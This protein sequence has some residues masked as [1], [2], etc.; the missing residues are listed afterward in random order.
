MINAV[1]KNTLTTTPYESSAFPTSSG[2]GEQI[3]ESYIRMKNVEKKKTEQET[4][5]DT[6]YPFFDIGSAMIKFSNS[7][8]NTYAT[9]YYLMDNVDCHIL[10]AISRYKKLNGVESDFSPAKSLLW[11]LKS[12]RSIVVS[13]ITFYEDGAK[14][15]LR[16]AQTDF[17]IDFDF[18][19]PDSVFITT[20]KNGTMFVKDCQIDDLQKTLE[21]F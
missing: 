12:V 19:E 20:F 18:E 15:R 10:N 14:I 11:A 4:K 2:S 7:A 21:L 1:L 8:E 17:I 9:R 13:R 3:S 6:F 5:G 16:F